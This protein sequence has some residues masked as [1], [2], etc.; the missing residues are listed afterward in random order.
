[1][2]KCKN[3]NRIKG[4]SIIR[5]TRKIMRLPIIVLTVLLLTGAACTPSTEN[6]PDSE[7][8]ARVAA[9]EA[10][11][12]AAEEARAEDMVA[13]R[14]DMQ[15]ILTYLDLVV[16]KL[17]AERAAEGGEPG[18]TS[19]IGETAKKAVDEGLRQLKEQAQELFD[20]LQQE[21]DKALG[22][23]EPEKEL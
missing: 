16:D 15:S 4:S 9:L 3:R 13:L 17:A 19:D 10:G 2:E 1:L 21:L 14:K 22:R 23:A 11:L 12:A 20:K 18:G 5:Q 6:T 8:E 7:L